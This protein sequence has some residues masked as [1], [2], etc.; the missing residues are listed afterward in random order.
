MNL[1]MRFP[2]EN[3]GRWD[4]QFILLKRVLWS[5]KRIA[6]M[7]FPFLRRKALYSKYL[8]KVHDPE[9]GYVCG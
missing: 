1:R 6:K 3:D 4:G 7:Q 8:R 5:P 9:T 2:P